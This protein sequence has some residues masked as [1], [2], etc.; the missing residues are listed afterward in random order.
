MQQKKLNKLHILSIRIRFGFGS[1][2][3]K[4]FHIVN[5]KEVELFVNFVF[6][7]Q[8]QNLHLHEFQVISVAYYHDNPKLYLSFQ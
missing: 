4:I 3:N 2:N 1:L 6:A 8:T 7:C 5:K